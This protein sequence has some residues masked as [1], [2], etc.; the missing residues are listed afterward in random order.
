MNKPETKLRNQIVKEVKAR[1]GLDLYLKKIHGSPYQEAGI[2]DLVGCFKG[3]FVGMEV[4]QPG[5]EPTP[6]QRA[7]INDI[8]SAG[9]YARVIDSVKE[10]VRF[11]DYVSICKSLN[12]K[13]LQK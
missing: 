3:Y 9:G 11:L 10:A 6:I 13:D 12:T 1:Y 5:E 8:I 2:P 7:N 4:K